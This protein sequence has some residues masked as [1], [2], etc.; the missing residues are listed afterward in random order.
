MSKLFYKPLERQRIKWDMGKALMLAEIM[1]IQADGEEA[2]YI[3]DC[4]QRVREMEK[5]YNLDSRVEKWFKQYIN[6]SPEQ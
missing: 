6:E 2:G 5:P 4:L 3:F 1:E